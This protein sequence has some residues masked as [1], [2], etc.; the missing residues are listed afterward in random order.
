MMQQQD[1]Q[2]ILSDD[3]QQYLHSEETGTEMHHA[4][5]GYFP[6]T[7]APLSG[8]YALSSKL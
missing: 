7:S 1:E 8:N 6:P 4:M 3:D 5:G 2:Q